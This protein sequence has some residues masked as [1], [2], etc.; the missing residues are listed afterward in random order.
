[1][2]Y[3]NCI[4][5]SL[6]PFPNFI[7]LFYYLI[8]IKILNETEEP[9]ICQNLYYYNIISLIFYILSNLYLVS[10]LCYEVPQIFYHRLDFHFIF[11]VLWYLILSILIIVGITFL[12]HND[13]CR[14]NSTNIY[15]LA[16]SNT[17]CQ[18]LIW[19]FTIII[20]IYYTQKSIGISPKLDNIFVENHKMEQ[21]I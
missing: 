21:I 2:N 10:L 8:S 7:I 18:L 20:V 6:C 1:M 15:N 12:N 5:I 13:R 14:D 19:I 11:Q 9:D 16:I 3:K 17:V 4:I